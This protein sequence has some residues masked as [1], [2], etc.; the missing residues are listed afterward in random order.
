LKDNQGLKNS[1]NGLAKTIQ[2]LLPLLNSIASAADIPLLESLLTDIM[3]VILD[4]TNCIG[5]CQQK[6]LFGKWL[7]LEHCEFAQI[8][9]NSED[10]ICQ[11]IDYTTEQVSIKASRAS[12]QYI[13]G[14]CCS[15]SREIECNE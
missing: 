9:I 2:G 3:K 11:G 7:T 4:A 12:K 13:I 10:N 1:L 8:C 5:A 14:P 15:N 6:N